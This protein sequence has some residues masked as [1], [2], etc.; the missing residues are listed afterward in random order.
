MSV[1]R[2]PLDIGG[3]GD[4][5]SVF[6]QDGAHRYDQRLNLQFHWGVMRGFED[7]FERR[8][9]DAGWSGENALILFVDDPVTRGEAVDEGVDISGQNFAGFGERGPK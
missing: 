9:I 2:V 1:R 7:D 6:A 3:E 4:E 5:A 8:W